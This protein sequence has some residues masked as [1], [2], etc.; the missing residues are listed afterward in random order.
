MFSCFQVGDLKANG[1]HF[2]SSF[3]FYTLFG[4]TGLVANKKLQDFLWTIHSGR[5]KVGKTFIHLLAHFHQATSRFWRGCEQWSGQPF[6]S[7][8]PEVF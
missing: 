8:F 7:G 4:K 3:G 6:F 2:L 5:E 1:A